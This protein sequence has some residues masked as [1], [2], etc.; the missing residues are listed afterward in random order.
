MISKLDKCNKTNL[1]QINLPTPKEWL[2]SFSPQKEIF[3]EAFAPKLVII[4]IIII[5]III[6]RCV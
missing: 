1:L 5:I 2:K 3:D 6:N 4:I